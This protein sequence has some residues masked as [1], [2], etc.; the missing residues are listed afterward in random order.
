MP[1]HCE[2]VSSKY[3]PGWNMLVS[4]V[5]NIGVGYAVDVLV[6]LR[7][8]DSA[9][10]FWYWLW[11][12][13]GCGCHRCGCHWCWVVLVDVRDTFNGGPSCASL[14]SSRLQF[15]FWTGAIGGVPVPLIKV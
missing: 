8:N 10:W 15:V 4:V 9:Y 3:T 12:A 1:F 14:P 7:L 13:Y 5:G 11:S 6:V 2:V